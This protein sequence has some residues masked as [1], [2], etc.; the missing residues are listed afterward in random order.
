VRWVRGEDGQPIYL[1]GFCE[2]ISQKKE[3][4][5]RLRDS[6]EHY[7]ASFEQSAVGI[8]HTS[9]SGEWLR[10]NRSFARIVGYDPDELVGMNFAQIT[11]PEDLSVGMAILEQ[12]RS[13]AKESVTFEKR[14][15][16]KDGNRIWA[17]VTTSMQRDSEGH[18][19]HLVATI[20]D[21]D[22]RKKA[23]ERLIAA[24]E[25]LT[26]S[27][28]RFRSTFE[29]A[30]VGMVHADFKGNWL[31]CNQRFA[32]IVGYEQDEIP[33]MNFQD[34]TLEED[35]A[36]GYSIL[37]RVSGGLIESASFEKRYLRKDGT[38][39]WVEVTAAVQQDSAG[40][41]PTHS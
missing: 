23:E 10:C 8:V 14:Y 37:E 22:A 3:T 19:Q 24:Q 11:E 29:Q 13:G 30:A 27:E 38:T 12:V 21:I 16:R 39:T 25:A 18:P 31:R 17:M 7:R 4:E 34:I 6:E 33:G 40:D 20:Q 32:R 35:R 26:E 2:D 5:K 15:I 1:E 41:C 36:E 9:F 28:E